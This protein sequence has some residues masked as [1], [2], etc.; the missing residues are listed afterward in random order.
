MRHFLDM[1]LRRIGL[2]LISGMGLSILYADSLT[3]DGAVRGA[4]LF[5]Y[6]YGLGSIACYLLLYAF[7]K[8]PMVVEAFQNAVRKI[9]AISS[10]MLV[11]G[12]ILMGA[13]STFALGAPA[14]CVA[15]LLVG[16]SFGF[17]LYAW[18]FI[19]SQ[20]DYPEMQK[21]M[22]AT[23]ISGCITF[24][25]LA[26]LPPFVYLVLLIAITLVVSKMG[27]RFMQ[28]T[29]LKSSSEDT[30][31]EKHQLILEARFIFVSIFTFGFVSGVS[32]SIFLNSGSDFYF[33]GQSILNHL[34]AEAVSVLIAVL[35]VFVT[36][37]R[38][39]FMIVFS[40]AFAIEATVAILVPFMGLWYVNVFNLVASVMA[41]MAKKLLLLVCASIGD[42][43][44]FRKAVPLLLAGSMIG[45]TLGIF[46]GENLY[47]F[48]DNQFMTLVAITVAVLYLVFLAFITLSAINGRIVGSSQKTKNQTLPASTIEHAQR[49]IISSF[50]KLYGLTNRESQV[51]E[52]LVKGRSSTFIAK[53]LYLSTNTVKSYSKNLYT[54]LE[55]HSKQELI[56]LFK[57]K[58][59][60]HISTFELQESM[61]L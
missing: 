45:A 5:N 4:D 53:E 49:K 15:G 8:K 56:D 50:S 42:Q 43:S 27:S 2:G 3:F 31:S 13:N 30:P 61:P 26:F 23:W 33:A 20:D 6:A 19:Y 41:K 14:E 11:C 25:I 12:V 28:T 18:L 39:N 9:M 51:L 16:C 40:A 24:A 60:G 36:R 17:L 44:V 10:P 57:E 48:L 7:L 38:P 37:K 59:K 29:E 32:G 55:V 22:L 52:L 34:T 1:N 58:T 46:L 47:A 54:K 21:S 35:I